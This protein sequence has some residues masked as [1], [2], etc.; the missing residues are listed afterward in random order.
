MMSRVI[1]VAGCVL[2][3]SGAALTAGQGGTVTASAATGERLYH[4]RGCVG[5]HEA[6]S[7]AS[8]SS[9]VS[10]SGTANDYRLALRSYRSGEAEHPTLSR[11]ASRL[12]DDEIGHLAQFLSVHAPPGLL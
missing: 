6:L 1:K 12:S 11:S 3:L 7:T 10:L 8:S 2:F 4:V 5:C 9:L